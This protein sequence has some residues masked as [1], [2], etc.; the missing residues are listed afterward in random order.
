ML[1]H[2]R[3]WIAQQVLRYDHPLHLGVESRHNETGRP[4]CGKTGR[5]PGSESV[6]PRSKTLQ[7]V[8]ATV[9]SGAED[10]GREVREVVVVL[11]S[12][13]PLTLGK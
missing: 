5:V 4:A 10:P 3:L 1:S 7:P 6:T 11:L 13:A 9:V 8:D 2:F 12:I